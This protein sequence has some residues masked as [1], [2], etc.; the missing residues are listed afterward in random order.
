MPHLKLDGP[1]P[2]EIHYEQRG[3]GP[4]LLL[5]MGLAT[6]LRAWDPVMPHLTSS[7]RVT[8]FDNRG[9]GLSGKPET[10]Y[11]MRQL[12]DDAVGV[13]D[14]LGIARAHVMGVSMGGMIAQHVALN[15]PDR[16]DRLV[17][18]VTSAGGR[19]LVSPEPGV[20]ARLF[21]PAFGKSADE[22]AELHGPIIFGDRFRREHPE[23]VREI[24]ARSLERP[25][26]PR[27]FLGQI[28]AIMGHDTSARLGDIKAR[29]LVIC[30]DDDILVP[31]G[32]SEKLADA[33][34]GAEL[35]RLEGAGHAVTHETPEELAAVVRRFL[36]AG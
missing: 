2:I 26:P 29:T 14:A 28:A 23:L 1:E 7:F 35:V 22:L 16:V 15:H 33:I 17:L 12:S 18:T 24:F 3:K 31:P 8:R 13:L 19:L 4:D 11:T 25:V 21:Q 10:D 32:N 5:I 36:K 30:G 34:A 27:C 20:M 9:V 6:D